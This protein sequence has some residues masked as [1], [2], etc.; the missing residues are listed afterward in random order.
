MTSLKSLPNLGPVLVSLLERAD[1]HSAE[2]LRSLGTEAVFTRLKV[3]ETEEGDSC[4]HKLYALEGAVQGIRWHDVTQE[5]RKELL[6]FFRR[7][8][9]DMK[10]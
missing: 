5:R 7:L 4:I 8:Q 6:E 2:E 9:H 3:L 10:K 1:I